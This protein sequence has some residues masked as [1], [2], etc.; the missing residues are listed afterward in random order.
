M[1]IA[2]EDPEFPDEYNRVISAGSIPNS[3]DDNETGE[4]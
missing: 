4:E 3:E 1:T 2:D